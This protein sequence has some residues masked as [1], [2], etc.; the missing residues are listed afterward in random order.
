MSFSLYV[1]KSRDHFEHVVY[2]VTTAQD[3]HMH[4]EIGNC[5]FRMCR[6]YDVT[7]LG[8]KLISVI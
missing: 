7:I 4:C 1:G 2:E 3:Y 8:I 5:W 6:V